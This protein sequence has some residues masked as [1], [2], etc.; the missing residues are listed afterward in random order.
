MGHRRAPAA[1]IPNGLRMNEKSPLN[2][3][4]VRACAIR[5]TT[6]LAVASEVRSLHPCAAGSRP[7]GKT[8]SRNVTTSH[9][10]A[11]QAH[12]LAHPTNSPAGSEAGFV[13]KEKG[14]DSP[15]KGPPDRKRT[16]PRM[17]QP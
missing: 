12:E 15:P 1:S 9:A 17:D 2:R 10:P 7:S 16:A 14:G 8:R 6:R 13:S 5:N 3:P 11:S 4:G